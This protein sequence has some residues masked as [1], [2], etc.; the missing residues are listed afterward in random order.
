MPPRAAAQVVAVCLFAGV[1]SSQPPPLPATEPF[2]REARAVF[3][4]SQ[5]VWHRYSYTER[6]TE[7]HMNPFGR[8]GTG[9]VRTFEVRPSPNPKLTYRRL[10]SR[11]GVALSEEELRRQDAEYASRSARLTHAGSNGDVGRRN[12]DLL[13]RKRAQMI[14]DDVVN[15]LQFDIV[16]RDFRGGVPA[17]VVSFAARPGAR[18]MTREGQLAS[19]MEGQLWIDEATREITDMTG[20]VTR[21]VAFGGFIAKVY[22]GTAVTVVRREIDPGVWMPTRLTLR[23]NVRALFRTARLDHIVEWTDYRRLP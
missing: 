18:P 9:A 23:G 2:L 15:T 13:A 7:L 22:D 10:I 20:E 6:S 1:A 8:M 21:D 4:R 17:I 12:E 14:V 5:E 16:R 11:D 19:A 3:T